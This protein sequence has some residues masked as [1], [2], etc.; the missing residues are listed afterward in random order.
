M[1]ESQESLHRI[2]PGGFAVTIFIG[3]A[4]YLGLTNHGWQTLLTF[5]AVLFLLL[6]ILLSVLLIG[7][8][9][10][11]ARVWMMKR[12]F[13]TDDGTVSPA[14]VKQIKLVTTVLMVVQVVVTFY[15]T[16]YA[17]FLYFS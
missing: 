8:P 5:K 15:V 10:H 3:S 7:V 1:S 13:S 14:K 16:K 11:L 17:Y 4:I 6:G 12:L 9:F 2:S